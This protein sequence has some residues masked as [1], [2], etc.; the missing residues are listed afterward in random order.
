M[1]IVIGS[2]LDY[3]EAV[4]YAPRDVR[5]RLVE[6]VDEKTATRLVG[7]DTPDRTN[8]QL[9]QFVPLQVEDLAAFEAAHQ[10]FL[11]RSDGVDDWVTLYHIDR[12]YTLR[13]LSRNGDNSLYIAER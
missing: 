5:D 6:V 1:P 11:V 10:N 2:P 8:R 13:L 4:E 9:A 7:T 3:L 12:K